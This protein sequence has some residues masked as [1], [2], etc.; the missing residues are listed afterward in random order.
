VSSLVI[1]HGESPRTRRLRHNRLRIALA[2]AAVEG[3]VVLA[4]GIPWWVVVLL[5]AAAVAFYVYVR[6]RGTG[7]SELVQLAWI[8]AF[9]QSALVLVPLI[10][11][12]LIV[13]AI[14]AVAVFAVVALIALARDRR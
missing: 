10:A 1:E 9:S 11:T 13:L 12:F 5:A 3:I 2:V 6:Q 4:G 14:F 8:A 7:S